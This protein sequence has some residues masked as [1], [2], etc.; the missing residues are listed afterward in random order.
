MAKSKPIELSE[1]AKMSFFA[2]LLELRKRIM[3]SIAAIIVGGFVAYAFSP[4]AIRW[5]ADFY[6]EASKQPDA[7][8]AQ[9]TVLDAFVLR[10]KVATY[11]GIVISSHVWLLHQG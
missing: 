6:V 5:I 1:K 8:L 2:H 4:W 7:Q 11:G 10:V 3:I 9:T